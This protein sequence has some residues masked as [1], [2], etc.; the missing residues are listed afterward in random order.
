MSVFQRLLI[1]VRDELIR[2]AHIGDTPHSIAMGTAC[3]ILI[4][5]TPL[6]GI[7]TIL[8]LFLAWIVRG[9]KLAAA[10]AVTLHDLL[11]PVLPAIFY[12]EYKL[13]YWMMRLP[14]VSEAEINKHTFKLLEHF[15]WKTLVGIGEPMLLGSIVIGLVSF[16]ATYFITRYFVIVYRAAKARRLEGGTLPD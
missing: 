8:A 5:F 15:S 6:Y 1:W 3:G 13:G 14:P 7:K 2:I 4:G 9:N 16:P 12:Y 11:L 10:I